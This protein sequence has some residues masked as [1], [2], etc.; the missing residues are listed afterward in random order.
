MALASGPISD[1]VK[2]ITKKT[3]KYDLMMLKASLGYRYYIITTLKNDPNK[4]NDMEFV[5]LLKSHNDTVLRHLD[6]LPIVDQEIENK[7]K[8]K[9]DAMINSDE[10]K[11]MV[12]NRRREAQER[13][14]RQNKVKEEEKNINMKQKERTKAR[15]AGV[16]IQRFGRKR[17]SSKRRSSFGRKRRSSKRR[18]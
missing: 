11:T 15:V 8:I 7:W 10:Y 3:S 14:D 2:K 13:V 5:A 6:N 9:Y 12:E 18:A 1:S 17:R 16:L 4:F